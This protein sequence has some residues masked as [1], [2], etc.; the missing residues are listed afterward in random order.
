MN[1]VAPWPRR[2][3]RLELREMLPEDVPRVTRIRQ[4]PG[5]DEWL[6]ND[7]VDPS[8]HR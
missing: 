1:Q 8:E 2:T 6:L 3:E 4:L 7:A 5:V